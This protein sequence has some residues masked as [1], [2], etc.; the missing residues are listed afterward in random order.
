MTRCRTRAATFF[1]THLFELVSIDADQRMRRTGFHTRRT[2]VA[3][4]AEVTFI[5]FGFLRA[6]AQPDTA[7]ANHRANHHLH[8]AIR[9]R[10]HTGFAPDAALLHHMHEAFLALN[11][12]V[13]TDVGARRVFTLATDSGGRNIHAFNDVDARQKGIR[14]ERGAILLCLMGHHARHFTGTATNAFAGIG[15]NKTVHLL[16][17]HNCYAR[18]YS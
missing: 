9:T 5:G 10:H 18:S 1:G 3:V 16:L 13:R 2:G 11:R 14:G 17:R 12:P 4:V 15:H 8:R 6:H 7:V